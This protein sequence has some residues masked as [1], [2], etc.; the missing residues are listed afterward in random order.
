MVVARIDRPV[1]DTLID[2][3][4]TQAQILIVRLLVVRCATDGEHFGTQWRVGEL[5]AAVDTLRVLEEH[6]VLTVAAVKYFHSLKACRI[7]RA[8]SGKSGRYT[9]SSCPGGLDRES[10]AL[11]KTRGSWRPASKAS[12]C[13]F[14]R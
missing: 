14:Y 5:V 7:V 2:I 10:Q 3:V 1:A 8:Q 4:L 9:Q 12:P 13:A 6:E 11:D